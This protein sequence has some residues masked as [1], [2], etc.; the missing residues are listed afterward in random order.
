MCVCALRC[1]LQMEGALSR[2]HG[3]WLEELPTHPEYRASLQAER[4]QWDREQVQHTHT[5]VQQDT[6]T[7]THTHTHCLTTPPVSLLTVSP[8]LLSLSSLSHHPS[9]LSLSSLSLSSLSHHPSC[10]SPLSLSSLSHHPSC[11]S[12]LSHHPSCLSPH[13]L[14]SRLP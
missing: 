6:H 11:L 5:Q 10:L 7:H 13:C 1:S 4:S 9:S 3:R 8:P 12:S 14:R 2:A